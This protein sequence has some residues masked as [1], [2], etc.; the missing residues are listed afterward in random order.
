[1]IKE[2]GGCSDDT[3]HVEDDVAFRSEGKAGENSGTI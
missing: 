1:M 3:E 2:E